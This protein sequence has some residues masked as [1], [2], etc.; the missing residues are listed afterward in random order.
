MS[1]GEK[2][3]WFE[4]LLKKKTSF[5]RHLRQ[6]IKIN[7]EKKSARGRLVQKDFHV[8]GNKVRKTRALISGKTI[9][10]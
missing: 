4:T 1:D 8:G 3:M 2:I 10:K 6:L 7:V 9:R 5:H